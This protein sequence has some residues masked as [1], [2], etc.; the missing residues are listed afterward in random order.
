M[1]NKRTRRNFLTHSAMMMGPFLIPHVL[2]KHNEKIS[3]QFRKSESDLI[4]IRKILDNKNAHIWVLTGDSITHGAKHTHGCRSYLEIF[5]E[6]LRWEMGRV[7]DFVINTGISGSTTRN[8]LQDF[9][10]R[11]AQFK[12]SVVSFMIGTNDVAKG[13]S[14]KEYT[15]NLVQLIEKIRALGAIPVLHTPNPIIVKLAPERSTLP[16][17]IPIVREVVA[18]NKTILVDNYGHWMEAIQKTSEKKVFREWLNDPLHPNQV[19]HQE[20]AK[21]MFKALDIFD[22]DAPTCGAPFYEGEH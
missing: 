9:E 15:S 7:R 21:E 5:E 4:G 1:I 6:R 20:I 13:V 3:N 11:I 17:L 16:E 8:L 12:P 22:P 14:K 19:G 2:P 10:W 18:E